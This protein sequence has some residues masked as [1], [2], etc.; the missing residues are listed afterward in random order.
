MEAL[1][2]PAAPPVELTPP[3]PTCASCGTP[4]AGI[5]CHACGEKVLHRHDY[6]LKH[7]LE[8]AV[9]TIT[10]F[11]LRVLRD[12]W[13][14]LRRPGFLAAEWLAGR[15]IRHAAPVQLF[16]ITNLLFYLL[17]SVSHFSPFETTLSSHL[18]SL[19]GYRSIANRL[20]LHRLQQLPTT[21][22]AYTNFEQ[23]FNSLAHTYSKSL[24]FLFIP[25]LVLPLWLLFWRQRR[26][27]VE[28]L[29]LSTYLF[30]GFLL[31]F[32]L[33]AALSL[34]S[35]FSAAL[36]DFFNTDGVIGPIMM[37][38]TVWYTAAFFARAFPRQV[39]PLRWGK[40]LLFGLAFTVMLLV[41][42]RFVLFLVCYWASS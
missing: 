7:F 27:F 11:D 14:Q 26:Y 31:V 22:T 6:A 9:D 34:T 40:A 33:S 3:P 39:W 41:P 10:H 17:A 35:H 16:L 36:A 28:W 23:H 21:G 1:A 15:R 30:A 8:H 42:Y 4:L 29:M 32:A 19:N 12:L 24:V 25:L 38:L 2:A 5:F 37:L 13:Q 18:H 20:L